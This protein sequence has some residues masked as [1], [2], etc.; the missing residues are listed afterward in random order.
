MRGIDTNIL[1]RAVLD[2]DPVQ[3]PKAAAFL[4]GLNTTNPGF[5]PLPVTLELYWV[6]KTRYRLSSE[7][8]IVFLTRL[9]A[10]ST[11]HFAEIES[12]VEAVRH[13]TVRK[14]DFS[15]AVIAILARRAGCAATM[16][17]DEKAVARVPAME[18]LA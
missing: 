5:V 11:I 1:L 14:A 9:F 4:L 15:D 7:A 2:D 12:L 8:I 10:T 3:S 17:F 16:T 13:V 6:L 18:L